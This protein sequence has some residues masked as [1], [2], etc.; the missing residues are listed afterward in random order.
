MV[1]MLLNIVY[2]LYID[3]S[4]CNVFYLA[5]DL[6]GCLGLTFGGSLL[7]I[8]EVVEYMATSV[9]ELLLSYIG[10][11]KKNIKPQINVKDIIDKS[12]WI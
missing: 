12:V 4:I 1:K 2:G 8:I 7:T 9:K 10:P 3:T 11:L 6:G 5:G